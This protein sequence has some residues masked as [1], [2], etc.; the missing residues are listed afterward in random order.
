MPILKRRDLERLVLSIAVLL[1]TPAIAQQAPAKP[2]E[3]VWS[4]STQCD[5]KR[6]LGIQIS[7]KGKVLYQDV[8]PICLSDHDAKEGRV[9]FHISGNQL[10]EGE[11][12]TRANDVLQGEIWEVAG[13]PDGLTFG[14]SFANNRQVLLKSSHTARMDRKT[15]TQ[16]DKDLVVSTYPHY[17]H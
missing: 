4:W 6:E 5:T 2:S 8:L 3:P 16:L 11:L 7:L 13:D 17:P 12:R 10:F 9:E 14:I 15:S 1:A